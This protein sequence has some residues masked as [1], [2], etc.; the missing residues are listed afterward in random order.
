MTN[1]LVRKFTH[2]SW[3][4]LKQLK[5]IKSNV[6]LTINQR[7]KFFCEMLQYRE[8]VKIHLNVIQQKAANCLI[9]VCFVVQI[10]LK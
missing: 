3:P 2:Q 10:N 5:Q 7:R 4:H 1:I 6:S 8:L 9:I